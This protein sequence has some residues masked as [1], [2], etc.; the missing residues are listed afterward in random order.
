VRIEVL[1][2]TVRVERGRA[3]RAQNTKILEPVVVVDTIDVIQDHRHPRA[4]PVFALA[5]HLANRILQA[6][7]KKAILEMGPAVGRMFDEDLVERDAAPAQSVVS[8]RI[9][10]EV[11]A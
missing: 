2:P 8:R 4:A 5:A 3:V 6:L 11:I 10:I 1:S 9:R 7:Q